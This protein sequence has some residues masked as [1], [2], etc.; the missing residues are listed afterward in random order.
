MSLSKVD[1]S[2]SVI[3]FL[4]KKKRK[5]IESIGR[6]MAPSENEKIFIGEETEL[7]RNVETLIATFKTQIKANLGKLPP[8]DT[9]LE[10][11]ILGA[12]ILEATALPK[13]NFLKVD[14]FYLEKNRI[15]YGAVLSLERDGIP[16][17]MRTVVSNLRKAGQLEAVDGAHYIAS[18]T[19]G[20]VTAANIE[21]HARILV[22]LS[23]KRELMMMAGQVMS[24]AYDEMTDSFELL[25]ST[26]DSVDKI[27][28]WIK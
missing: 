27:E 7:C 24:D 23:I 2:I 28:T 20:V 3:E 14:H 19:L 16:V 17:D 26:K 10:E 1:Q 18:L 12:V 15:V 5:R 13:V 4:L 8:Q 6:K 11:T 22:E 9:R 25:Q 21:Y